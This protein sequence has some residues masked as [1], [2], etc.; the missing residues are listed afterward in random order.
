MRKYEND[1]AAARGL[2]GEATLVLIKQEIDFAVIGGWV[3]YLFNANPLSHPGTYDVDVLLNSNTS[4]EAMNKAIEEFMRVGYL[5]SPKNAFQLYRIL[6]VDDEDRIFHV[7]FL[8]RKYAEDTDDLIKDWGK[9]QSIAGPGTD[10]IFLENER[11]VETLFFELP[12]G[13]SQKVNVTFCTEVGLLS[14]KGRSAMTKKRTRDAYDIFLVVHQSKNKQRLIERCRELLKDPIFELSFR[15][16]RSGFSLSG[17]LTA[18]VI[19]HLSKQAE[20]Q[21]PLKLI[22]SVMDEF[23]HSI[24]N[25][26]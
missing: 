15:E 21:D 10:I 3:P 18:N 11:R 17:P 5:R 25:A 8:H 16:I 6:R 23:F 20:I 12:N 22:Q 9:I 4:Y 24:L 26:T 1:L 7:D 19:L 2:L 14:A 13:D